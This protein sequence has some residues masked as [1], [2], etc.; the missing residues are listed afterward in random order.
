MHH[1][2]KFENQEKYIDKFH[3]IIQNNKNESLQKEKYLKQANMFSTS[4]YTDESIKYLIESYQNSPEFQNTIFFIFGDHMFGPIPKNNPLEKFLVPLYIYS[5][6][7]HSPKTIKSINSHLDIP[8]SVLALLSKKYNFKV[9]EK[10]HWLGEPFDIE[11]NENNAKKVLL[12]LNNRDVINHQSGNY[13][14]H[15]DEV[16]QLDENFALKELEEPLLIEKILNER[17]SINQMHQIIIRDNKIAMHN[18]TFIKL[19]AK[20]IDGLVF[21]QTE[22]YINLIERNFLANHSELSLNFDIVIKQT[23]GELNID[24]LP[25][26]V[27]RIKDENNNLIYWNS[28]DFKNFG[29]INKR[30][31]QLKRSLLFKSN[32][33]LPL[34]E[35]SNIKIYFWNYKKSNATFLVEKGNIE[36]KTIKK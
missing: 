24:S 11:W 26:L 35:K 30:N 17:D 22:E 29:Q 4:I 13:F 9:P 25:A 20:Q 34:K 36:L 31:L 1:P 19:Q 12:M 18:D 16:Y 23:Y 15:R 27:I 7:I 32:S 5:P 10:I 2:F 3:S 21:K 8:P 28:F 6:L 33:M 14:T